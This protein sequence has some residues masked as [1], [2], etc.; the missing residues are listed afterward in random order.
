M[1]DVFVRDIIALLALSL[2]NILQQRR[3][4]ERQAS[5]KCSLN[6]LMVRVLTQQGQP[7]DWARLIKNYQINAQCRKKCST[8]LASQPDLL[9]SDIISWPAGGWCRGAGCWTKKPE[10]ERYI[11]TNT[12]PSRSVLVSCCAPAAHQ[13]PQR[14]HKQKCL[15]RGGNSSQAMGARGRPGKNFVWKLE[16]MIISSLVGIC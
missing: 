10:W 9:I 7:G 8:K 3:E 16:T 6:C 15:V 2:W 4:E 13:R 1:P 11:I 5:K 12:N 14:E